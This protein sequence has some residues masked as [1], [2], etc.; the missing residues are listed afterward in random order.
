LNKQTI[1]KKISYNV[2]LP[3]LYLALALS[4]TLNPFTDG[5]A[6]KGFDRIVGNALMS[7]INISSVLRN[8]YFYICILIPFVTMFFYA[9]L[10]III[11]RQDESINS[12]WL[13]LINEI[14][15]VGFAPLIF[16]YLTRYT[17]NFQI[18][19]SIIIP[20]LLIISII[21]YALLFSKKYNFTILKWSSIGVIPVVILL[22]IF[23]ARM[24]VTLTHKK[25]AVSY[26]VLNWVVFLAMTFLNEK[27]NFD[28]LKKSYIIFMFAPIAMSLGIELINILSQYDVF[29]ITK[30]KFTLF[31][32]IIFFL[33]FVTLYLFNRNSDK[34]LNKHLD[35]IYFITVLLSLAFI[36]TQ[37]PYL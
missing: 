13:V 10:Y 8:I 14:A 20:V 19:M 27:V 37:M 24:G 12:D 9:L 28:A 11:N 7:G 25:V 6:L 15:T 2:L 22:S 17:A 34:P 23:L 4:L 18:Q 26:F 33:L 29:I 31:I 36:W 16:S 35:L 5:V 30:I 32:Y 1:S 21:I 3:S